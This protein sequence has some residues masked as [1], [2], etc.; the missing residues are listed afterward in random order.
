M[1][2][3]H[4]LPHGNLDLHAHLA[5]ALIPPRVQ[6]TISEDNEAT[7]AEAHLRLEIFS[8]IF[9]STSD[10]LPWAPLFR[11]LIVEW[12]VNGERSSIGTRDTEFVVGV[13]SS[14]DVT[15]RG[16]PSSIESFELSEGFLAKENGGLNAK[17]LLFIVHAKYKDFVSFSFAV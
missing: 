14:V 12:S 2:I 7:F 8:P 17:Y 3:P 13:G 11:P 6:G 1:N 9:T 15:V 4:S 10:D 16:G 5:P